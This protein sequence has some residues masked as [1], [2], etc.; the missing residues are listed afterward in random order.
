MRTTDLRDRLRRPAHSP[1][2]AVT[3]CLPSRRRALALAAAVG[4]TAAMPSAHAQRKAAGP[5]K[6]DVAELMKPG[7]LPDLVL[8]KADAPV[9]IVEYA[10]MTCPS[11]ANF[12]NKVLPE[13]KAKY[14]DTG[15][16]RLVL[17][18]FPLDNLAAAGSMLSRCA[19][20]P[21]KSYAL[22]AILFAKQEEW[23]FVRTNPVP[24][25]FKI[26]K[27]A[28]FTQ[29][30][31]DKCLTDQKLLDDINAVRERGDKVFGVSATPSFFINGARF[32]ERSDKV[33]NF[34]KVIDPLLPKS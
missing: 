6:I 8:G 14:I 15:K 30:S 5:D 23:A 1:E 21:E 4:M 9:T 25:L 32:K 28:G 13:L 10:S 34:F 22:T 12:H 16:A 27:Q 33:E 26:A 29:E 7:N 3:D 24:E 18:E 31:F 20:S 2:T 11:C 19:G 17:R